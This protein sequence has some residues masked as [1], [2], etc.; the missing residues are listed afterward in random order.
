MRSNRPRRVGWAIGC[1]IVARTETLRRL[2]PF[3]D[4]TFLF[5]E[6]MDLGLRAR[7]AG[8]ET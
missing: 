3:D 5:A 6:D 2:G 8:I 7:A 4:E 1:C